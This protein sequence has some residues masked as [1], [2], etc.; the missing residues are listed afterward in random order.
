[1]TERASPPTKSEA[2][3]YLSRYLRDIG[4]TDTNAAAWLHVH[5]PDAYWDMIT[6]EDGGKTFTLST[7]TRDGH[8]ERTIARE[9]LTI[10]PEMYPAYPGDYKFTLQFCSGYE[11]AAHASAGTRDVLGILGR[12]HGGRESV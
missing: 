6:S 11:V 1:M 9:S 2:L 8:R 3:H 12:G 7:Y 10:L 4:D 5:K